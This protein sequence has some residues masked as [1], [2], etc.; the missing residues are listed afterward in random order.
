MSEV[1]PL[2]VG[3]DS[4]GE[5]PEERVEDFQSGRIESVNLDT[6][7]PLG[8]VR[9]GQSRSVNQLPTSPLP[10][11]KQK[12]KR[13][14]SAYPVGLLASAF[15]LLTLEK[16]RPKNVEAAPIEPYTVDAFVSAY[17]SRVSKMT[18]VQNRTNPS[19]RNRSPST[20]SSHFFGYRPRLIRLTEHH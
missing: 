2:F 10:E 20:R 1:P 5:A 14:K 3:E 13:A 17:L 9:S 4:N 16:K 15:D 7:N 12:K 8:S 18:L 19:C 6:P 11:V